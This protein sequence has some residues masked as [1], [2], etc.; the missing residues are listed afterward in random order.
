M[1]TLDVPDELCSHIYTH[2]QLLAIE[3]KFRYPL[4]LDKDDGIVLKVYDVRFHTVR[5][6]EREREARAHTYLV[7]RSLTLFALSSISVSL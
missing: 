3:E 4:S 5:T 1:C 6:R 2:A 7:R